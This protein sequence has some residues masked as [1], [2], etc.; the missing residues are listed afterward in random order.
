MY[1]NAKIYRIV[2]DSQKQTYY[3][4]TC[5]PLTK[6]IHTFKAE[7][8]THKDD[9]TYQPTYFKILQYPD[10]KIILVE[11]YPCS[12][13]EELLKKEREYIEQNECINKDISDIP[14]R[15]PRRQNKE[16][17]VDNTYTCESCNIELSK[18]S[19]TK[20]QASKKHLNNA[21]K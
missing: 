18:L 5:S 21:N 11:S 4:S 17:T 20:H 16:R 12:N 14:E 8:S 15:K 10:A 1:K 13:K 6:R 3:G 19:I 7:Y 9:K 2:S